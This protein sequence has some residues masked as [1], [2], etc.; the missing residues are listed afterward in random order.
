MIFF[1]AQ[2]ISQNILE[3]LN[4]WQKKIKNPTRPC[5]GG[6]SWARELSWSGHYLLPLIEMKLTLNSLAIA[7]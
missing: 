1:S 5:L 2:G 6:E 7:Q 3:Y 4:K